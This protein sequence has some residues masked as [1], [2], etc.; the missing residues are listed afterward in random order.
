MCL[1]YATPTKKL[2]NK[3]QDFFI[4]NFQNRDSASIQSVLHILLQLAMFFFIQREK[5]GYLRSPNKVPSWF[6]LTRQT[7]TDASFWIADCISVNSNQM[8]YNDKLSINIVT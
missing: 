7:D 1:E 4:A 3:C 5:E 8:S 2:K 6:H